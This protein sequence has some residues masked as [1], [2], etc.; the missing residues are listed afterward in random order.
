MADLFEKTEVDWGGAMT[1][2]FGMLVDQNGLSGVLMQ[3]M[4]L[5]Y[6]QNVTRLYEIG[7]SNTKT[8]VYYVGGRAQGT[9]S[10]GHVVGPGVSMATYYSNYGSVCKAGTNNLTLNIGPNVCTE[11]QVKTPKLQY[12]ARLCVLMS[13]GLS[14]AA[15]DFVINENS[16]MMFS[17]L[18]YKE[19]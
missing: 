2:Q 12:T 19:T 17:G 15:Q 6:Q 14:V 7:K 3:N 8:K 18:E 1:S 13:V 11:N 5:G 9:L 16:Q 4:Q 10:A